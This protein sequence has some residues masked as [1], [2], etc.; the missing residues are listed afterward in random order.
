MVATFDATRRFVSIGVVST[1]VGVPTQTLRDWE[2]RGWIPQPT[3]IAGLDRRVYGP[4]DV[5]AI[6]RACEARRVSEEVTPAR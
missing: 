3:R 2:A 5:E 1:L 4:E 6:R